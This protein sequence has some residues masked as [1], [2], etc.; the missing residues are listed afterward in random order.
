M[1]FLQGNILTTMILEKMPC[2]SITGSPVLFLK[3]EKLPSLI[4]EQLSSFLQ[5]QGKVFSS[6]IERISQYIV[7]FDGRVQCSKKK[8]TALRV[9]WR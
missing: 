9:C 1:L 6:F 5:M 4:Q 8:K 2:Y 3:D 7:C